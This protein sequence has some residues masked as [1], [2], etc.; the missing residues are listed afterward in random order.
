MF[1]SIK[2]QI[3]ALCLTSM[4]VLAVC[5]GTVSVL[6]IDRLTVDS[7]AQNMNRVAENQRELINVELIQA[8]DVTNFVARDIERRIGSPED[9]R[10]KAVRQNVAADVNHS[11]QN[12][13]SNV[14]FICSYYI[15]YVESLAGTEDN[16]WR[17][18]PYNKTEFEPHRITPVSSYAHDDVKHTS[19]YTLPVKNGKAVWVPPYYSE[20]QKRYMLSYVVPIYK[21]DILVAVVGVDIDFQQFL[22]RIE[23]VPEYASGKAFC[24]DLTGKI[25]YTADNPEGIEAS[26]NGQLLQQANKF[27]VAPRNRSD[28]LVRY[29]WNGVEYDTTAVNLRNGLALMVLAPVQEIHFM[30]FLRIIQLVVVFIFMV[31]LF[32][33]ISIAVTRRLTRRLQDLIAVANDIAAGNLDVD[34]PA[35]GRDEIGDLS[36]ALGRTTNELKKSMDKMERMTYYDSLTGLL[37]RLGLD[38]ALRKWWDRSRQAV[39]I[40]MDIDDFK[41]INDLYGHDAGDVAL[42]RMAEILQSFFGSNSIVARNGGDEFVV[43][44]QN[45][46]L[47]DALPR[48]Q[49]FGMMAK[50]YTVGGQN[51]SFTTSAGFSAYPQMAESLGDL[52]R[53]SDEA[54]YAVKL[55]GKN[56]CGVYDESL[57]NQ[58]RSQLGFNLRIVSKNLPAA[59]CIYRLD[60]DNTLLYANDMFLAYADCANMNEL[61]KHIH[62]SVLK[63]LPAEEVESFHQDVDEAQV[64]HYHLCS[65]QGRRL[66]VAVR[67]RIVKHPLY[68]QICYSI[69]T[70]EK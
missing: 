38:E 10:S 51:Y 8:E 28:Q 32:S 1:R 64:Y 26:R 25:H 24:T 67:R 22:N 56:N 57:A 47:E 46:A 45:I 44:M 53:Q 13:V 5:M 52:F 41:L 50:H 14:D 18:R 15:Y 42:Q 4:F 34:V 33:L 49:E 27:F 43:V 29:Q 59:L 66:K 6:S 2:M 36:R 7:E 16:L 3:L 11:F 30:S 35:G 60:K 65:C 61:Q 37:N 40:T 69:M 39:L 12:A 63:L 58:D 62:S 48:I 9:L 20:A 19:W 54:L 68:G 55:K 70:E 17:V 31:V 21:G 23:K